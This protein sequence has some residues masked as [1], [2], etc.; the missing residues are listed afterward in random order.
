MKPLESLLADPDEEWEEEN[1]TTTTPVRKLE[2][3]R[4]PFSWENS[5]PECWFELALERLNSVAQTKPVQRAR[6]LG[7]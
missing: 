5:A 2:D 6:P 7:A 4:K 1:M 3:R